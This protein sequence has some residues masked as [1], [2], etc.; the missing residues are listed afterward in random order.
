[1]EVTRQCVEAKSLQ[2][3]KMVALDYQKPLDRERE[4]WTKQRQAE[5]EP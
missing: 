5:R 3:Q 4:G 1:M 2:E